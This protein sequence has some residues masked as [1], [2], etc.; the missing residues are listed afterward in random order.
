MT[1]QGDSLT[2]ATADMN[3]IWAADEDDR[4]KMHEALPMVTALTDGYSTIRNYLTL[5]HASIG[6]VLQHAGKIPRADDLLPAWRALTEEQRA[7]H[8]CDFRVWA[9]GRQVGATTP[10][11]GQHGDSQSPPSPRPT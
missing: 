2:K 10:T 5:A 1:A 7:E 8:A 6:D 9:N 4:K 3:A 11:L